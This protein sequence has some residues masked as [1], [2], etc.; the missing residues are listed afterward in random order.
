MRLVRQFISQQSSMLGASPLIEAQ[1]PYLPS[2]AEVQDK[3]GILKSSV[4]EAYLC[5]SPLML[6]VEQ[7]IKE[8]MVSED[9]LLAEI[10]SYLQDQGGK[11]VRPLLT[12]LSAELFLG[13]SKG[14]QKLVDAATGI[15]LIHMATLLHDD[16]IDCSAKRRHKVS[17]Y[18]KFGPTP[19]LLAGDFLLARA[20]GLCGLLDAFVVRET[21]KACVR[22]SEGELI[23]GTLSETRRVSYEQYLNIAS[24]K[25]AALFSLAATVG[26]YLA[27]AQE[28]DVECLR[29]FGEYAGIAFQMADDIL[30]VQ[31][32]EDLLGKPS[33]TDLKQKTPSLINILW[34][35]R[36][37]YKAES[38]FAE[39]EPT[40]EQCGEVLNYLKDSVIVEEAQ[41]LANEYAKKAVASLLGIR[42]SRINLETREKLHALVQYSVERCL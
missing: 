35:S 3:L 28:A 24:K 41:E 16:I 30:D 40:K 13:S 22:L 21:E 15:E 18:C 29:R 26:A 42:S 17:A 36:D 37:P 2:S 32:D 11:R 14:R 19:S 9:K 12:F 4:R 33:G 34:L 38:F 6:A 39:K 25:T 20:F 8:V 7:R 10:A 23:E 31:A 27:G 5:V 1:A